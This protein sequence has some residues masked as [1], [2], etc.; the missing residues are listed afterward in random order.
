MF[1]FMKSP[2]ALEPETFDVRASRL[3]HTVRLGVLLQLLQVAGPRGVLYPQGGLDGSQPVV[4][5]SWAS[6]RAC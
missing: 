2:V 5:G 6:G 4:H 1:G 3:R